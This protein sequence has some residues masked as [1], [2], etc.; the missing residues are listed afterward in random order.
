M[1]SVIGDEDQ[2]KKGGV[3]VAERVTSDA[4]EITRIYS[5]SSIHYNDIKGAP[6]PPSF[7]SHVISPLALAS[8]SAAAEPT[9]IYKKNKIKITS[10]ESGA[11]PLRAP[12]TAPVTP[13]RHPPP[14]SRAVYSHHHTLNRLSSSAFYRSFNHRLKKKRR[15]RILP[16][17]TSSL[18]IFRK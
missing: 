3:G 14:R 15:V 9:V 8:S 7:S 1:A 16:R 12:Q 6:T 5:S 13:A 17:V 2:A 4:R 11:P 10:C 18:R